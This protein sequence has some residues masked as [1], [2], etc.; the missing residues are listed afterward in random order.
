[1]EYPQFKVCVRC[2]TFNQSKFITDAMDGFTLQQTSFP[3]V[4]CI[5]D[6]A[7]TD[8]EQKVIKRYIIEHFNLQD[9][10][11]S[12]EKETEY[13][14]IIFAQHITNHNCYFA[15]LFLKE[16]L[17]S[18]KQGYKKF[19]YISEWRDKCEYEAMCEGDDYWIVPDKLERQVQIMDKN[20]D[21][22]LVYS[23]VKAITE[24]G[25]TYLFGKK[26]SSF[27]ELL[28]ENTIPTLTTCYRKALYDNYLLEINPAKQNWKMGDYPLW[29]YL[30][31]IGEIN[32][33]NEISGIYRVLKESASHSNDITKTIEF[34]ENYFIIKRH[35]I[36]K[37]L[38][39]D[40]KLINNI[41]RRKNWSIFV[42]YIISGDYE[43]AFSYSKVVKNN[44]NFIQ[45]IWI[46]LFKLF[47]SF[48]T[49]CRKRWLRFS[50]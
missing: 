25:N 19:D 20:P 30:S 8:D 50:K 49:V 37:Y 40:V 18:K 33:V 14:H 15:A 29:L 12:F 17:Y 23:K 36:D 46:Y 22:G 34:V 45:C 32:F 2:F 41:E 1:M 3:Y 31:T 35:F 5:V 21:V 11:V 28:R 16:N 26:V 43:T 42:E 10:I 4:C 39:G 24:S 27:L 9:S 7:S 13:A 38:D 6:D 47:P 48:R 44:F